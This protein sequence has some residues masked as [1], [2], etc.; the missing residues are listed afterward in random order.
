VR[1]QI[2]WAWLQPLP[3][4]AKERLVD[5][6]EAQQAWALAE[7]S[8][9]TTERREWDQQRQLATNRTNATGS[10]ATRE[11]VPGAAGEPAPDY[12]KYRNSGDIAGALDAYEEDRRAGRAQ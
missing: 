8:R 11:L 7:R 2:E 10:G 3:P 4:E 12:S 5:S 1:Q 6:I 9:L